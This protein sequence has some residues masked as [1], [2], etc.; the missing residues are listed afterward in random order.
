MRAKSAQS[1][2]L[3]TPVAVA[4]AAR[5]PNATPSCNA[6]NAETVLVA[7]DDAAMRRLILEAGGDY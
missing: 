5:R 3:G 7:D 4:S 6:R 1:A 2:G